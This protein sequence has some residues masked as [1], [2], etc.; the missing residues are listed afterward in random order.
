M[1][2]LGIGNMQN[3]S[4]SIIVNGEV[5]AAAE[6]ERFTRKKHHQGFPIKSISYCLEQCNISIDDIDLIAVGWNPF[7]GTVHR[8]YETLKMSIKSSGIAKKVKRG[9]GYFSIIKEQLSINHILRTNFA[10]R[11]RIPIKY[12]N[13]H[14]SHAAYCSYLSPYE[15]NA[16]LITDGV[17]EYQT[18]SLG[19]RNKNNFRNMLEIKYPYSLG[20]I[21][22]IFTS[23]LGFKP[24]NGEGKVMGLAAYVQPIF[25]EE[26][27]KLVRYDF[28]NRFFK[29]NLDVFDYSQCLKRKFSGKFCEIFGDPRKPESPITQKDYNVAATVQKIT[30]D[31]LIN[32]GNYLFEIT[33]TENLCIAGGVAMN[34]LANAKIREQTKFKNIFVPPA[35][36]DAGV[37]LGAALHVSRIKKNPEKRCRTPFLGPS[38]TNEEIAKTIRD[39][40]IEGF[41]YID[42]IEKTC[43]KLLV[44]QKIV[45]WFQGRMELSEQE[46]YLPCQVLKKLKIFLMKK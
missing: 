34:C 13:H 6:E 35:P 12:V 16:Y 29:Y 10:A 40:N 38:F 24:N 46:A 21:Y 8:I 44:D 37:S 2:I 25:Y 1:R 39:E 27:S 17:G 14:L 42:D 20:H 26:L 36:T 41:K 33:Q 4:A 5:Q 7:Q 15:E 30:E 43:A 45:G 18:F 11:K 31:I 28:K 19:Y 3:S 32:A 23:F 9:S 22:S